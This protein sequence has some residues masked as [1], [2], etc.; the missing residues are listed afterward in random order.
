[1][2]W[3]ITSSYLFFAVSIILSSLA[4]IQ[5]LSTPNHV[6]GALQSEGINSLP[7]DVHCGITNQSSACTSKLIST[8]AQFFL[9]IAHCSAS[10]SPFLTKSL[11]AATGT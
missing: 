5:F 6:V 8:V 3:L 2:P 11:I 1:L 4:S 10:T 9:L 7:R